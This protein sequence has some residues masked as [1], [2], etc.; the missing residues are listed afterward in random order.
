MTYYG[1]INLVGYIPREV[2]YRIL[3]DLS[4]PDI[5]NFCSTNNEL[6]SICHDDEFWKLK[7]MSNFP[8]F[9]SMIKNWRYTAHVLQPKPVIVNEI[10]TYFT[11][12]SRVKNTGEYQLILDP[13]WNFN[14]LMTKL[15]KHDK[16]IYAL[17][18]TFFQLGTNKYEYE[19][20]GIG[21]R[22]VS[23]TSPDMIYDSQIPLYL[24]LIEGNNF[25]EKIMAIIKYELQ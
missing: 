13:L 6:L 4:I 10:L 23:P 14:F 5:E 1:L 24:L 18:R 19:S 22:L 7:V 21:F 9:T 20:N 12:L 15:Y 17:H 2:V 25:Y 8:A 16:I 3:I 11:Y